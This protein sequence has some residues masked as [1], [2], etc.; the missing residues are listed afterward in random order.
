[1]QGRAAMRGSRTCW[2]GKLQTNLSDTSSKLEE[3]S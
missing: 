3:R 1:M 2:H